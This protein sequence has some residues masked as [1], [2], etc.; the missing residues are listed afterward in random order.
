MTSFGTVQACLSI[1]KRRHHPIGNPYGYSARCVNL[2]TL[3]GTDEGRLIPAMALQ[4]CGGFTPG[5]ASAAGLFRQRMP[6]ALQTERSRTQE[7]GTVP[8][9]SCGLPSGAAG[10]A[11]GRCTRSPFALA[12]KA[13]GSGIPQGWIAGPEIMTGVRSG[14]ALC[15]WLQFYARP[16][17]AAEVHFRR[18]THERARAAA[19]LPRS[20]EWPICSPGPPEVRQPF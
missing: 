15:I 5:L 14:S 12:L 10:F 4:N 19:D 3:K 6:E 16:F 13:E 20:A 17:T 7:K 1:P 18:F 11:A 2:R 9:A 8:G